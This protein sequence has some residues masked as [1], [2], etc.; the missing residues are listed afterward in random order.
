[1]FEDNI[2]APQHLNTPPPKK[3]KLGLVRNLFMN[4]VPRI[5]GRIKSES[6]WGTGLVK[7][8]ITMI[9]SG[10]N[11]ESKEPPSYGQL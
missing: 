7:Q 10:S 3:K 6:E 1:M 11:A 4:W 5:G 9:I 2:C 8:L